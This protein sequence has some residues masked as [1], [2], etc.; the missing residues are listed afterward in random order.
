MALA[1]P[2]LDRFAVLTLAC[3]VVLASVVA[4]TASSLAATAIT[5]SA[6]EATGAMVQELAHTMN[7]Q[8]FLDGPRGVARDRWGKDLEQRLAVLPGLV[9]VKIWSRNAEILWSDVPELVGKRFPDNLNL[10]KALGGK[11][12][13]EMTQPRAGEHL[14]EIGF[15][16][17]V[18]EIYVP[19]FGRE[20][21][22]VLGVLEVYLKTTALDDI[23]GTIDLVIWSVS[24]AGGLALAALLVLVVRPLAGSPRRPSE[25]EA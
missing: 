21:G 5:R 9:R 14:Y 19:I 25:T 23:L 22:Q 13:S 17:R 1:R 20:S 11:V 7:V 16:R 6:I 12:S 15:Y 18:V 8:A 10:R 4:L 3:A 2:R 24:L